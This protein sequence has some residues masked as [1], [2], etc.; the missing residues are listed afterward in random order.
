[1]D[2]LINIAVDVLTYDETYLS[3][4]TYD[5]HSIEEYIYKELNVLKESAEPLYILY[6]AF[7]AIIE[8]VLN[9]FCVLNSA[10][11]LE[12]VKPILEIVDVYSDLKVE[13]FVGV[14]IADCRCRRLS[15][16][17]SPYISEFNILVVFV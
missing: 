12:I 9:C 10:S 1:V 16:D 8:L 3:V 17:N 14:S 11:R 2:K 15:P 7:L 13:I 5:E 6:A 4:L